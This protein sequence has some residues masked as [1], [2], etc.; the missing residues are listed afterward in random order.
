ME[1]KLTGY[2]AGLTGAIQRE[3]ELIKSDLGRVVDTLE[4]RQIAARTTRG[5]LSETASTQGLPRGHTYELPHRPPNTATNIPRSSRASG[6]KPTDTQQAPQATKPQNEPTITNNRRPGKPATKATSPA[7]GPR[8]P[9]ELKP[10]RNNNKEEQRLIFHHEAGRT[11]AKSPQEDA[12]LELNYYLAQQG[13]PAFMQAVDT[14]YTETGSLSILLE[15]GALTGLVL[16]SYKD[17]LLAA[18]CKAD[19]AV[20]SMELNQQ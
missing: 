19:Q 12:I 6:A 17:P 8:D 5:K 10:T 4:A 7:S 18:C 2:T 13:F 16:S 20:I 11:A 14:N 3:L 9:Q 15:K 1:D